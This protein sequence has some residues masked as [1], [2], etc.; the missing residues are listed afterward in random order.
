M[1]SELMAADELAEG[2]LAAPLGF[3]ADGSAYHLISPVPFADDP[4]RLALLDW[5]RAEAEE[6]HAA[7]ISG[8]K[9]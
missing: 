2:R 4:R 3:V 1:A 8:Q 7:R 9:A 5:L 6:S